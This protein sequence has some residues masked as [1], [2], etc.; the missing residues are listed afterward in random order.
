MYKIFN[1]IFKISVCIY[2]LIYIV[3]L[4][5]ILLDKFDDESKEYTFKLIYNHSN[6]SDIMLELAH[7][8]VLLDNCSIYTYKWILNTICKYKMLSINN[9]TYNKSIEKLI[10]ICAN[11]FIY[12]CVFIIFIF[13]QHTR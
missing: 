11:N 4:F 8:C 7:S 1:I 13:K 6:V 10:D 12:V 2:I 5:W 9:N 3:K